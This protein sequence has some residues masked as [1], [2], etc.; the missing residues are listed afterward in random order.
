SE[1]PLARLRLTFVITMSSASDDKALRFGTTG[2]GIDVH[3]PLIE[4]ARGRARIL[5]VGEAD[6]FRVGDAAAFDQSG[7]T[8]DIVASIG[9]SW[10]GGG[11][12][13]TLDLMRTAADDDAWF[14]LGDVFGQ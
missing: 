5:G 6:E 4:Q 9:T 1:A 10:I 12:V 3:P 7:R 13:G 14:L 11:L 2:V 8:F